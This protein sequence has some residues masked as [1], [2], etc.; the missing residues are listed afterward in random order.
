MGVCDTRV[1]HY[2]LA[3]GDPI[4]IPNEFLADQICPTADLSLQHCWFDPDGNLI[5]FIIHEDE[6]LVGITPPVSEL[7]YLRD[8]YANYLIDS[9][10]Q[11]LYGFNLPGV[12]V[13]YLADGA[14]HLVSGGANL[15]TI[16]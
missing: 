2:P 9:L 10:S 3:D 16:A 6:G 8:K 1:I 4:N 7:A 13:K 12:T 5:H 11:R 14:D 15:F